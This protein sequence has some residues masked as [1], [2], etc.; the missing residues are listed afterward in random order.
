MRHHTTS[1]VGPDID[2]SNHPATPDS[3]PP[4]AQPS[5]GEKLAQVCY[6]AF[7]NGNPPEGYPHFTPWFL[8]AALAARREV[9]KEVFAEEDVEAAA[10]AMWNATLPGITWDELREAS[11]KP[12]WANKEFA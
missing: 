12:I 3:C 11:R 10:K 2:D 4:P 6:E 7:H 9:L 8:S 5:V 1:I